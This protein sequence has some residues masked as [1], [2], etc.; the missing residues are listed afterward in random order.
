MSLQ[1]RLPVGWLALLCLFSLVSA[2]AIPL[3]GA[4]AAVPA[5]AVC[6]GVCAI[7]LITQ[8]G[9]ARGSILLWGIVLLQVTSSLLTK[10]A[11]IGLS[12]VWQ[13]SL[14]I[15]G[16]FGFVGLITAA[17]CDRIFLPFLIFTAGFLLWASLSTIGSRA[18]YLAAAY[19]FASDLK[20]LLLV[21]LGFAIG[22]SSGVSRVF[23]ALAKWSWL[24]IVAV[25]AVEWALPGIYFNVFA[26]SGSVRGT[27]DPI[28]IFP[29]R[30]MSVFEHP[31]IMASYAAF[32]ALYS[33]AMVGL[34]DKPKLGWSLLVAAYLSIMVA[35]VQRQELAACLFAMI[36]MYLLKRRE[37]VPARLIGAAIIGVAAAAIFWL[38]FSDN[39]LSEAGMW[40]IGNFHTVEHPRAQIFVGSLNVARQYWPFGS[41]LGTYG[42]AGAEK[43]DLSFYYDLGFGRYWW[44]GKQDYLLDTYWPNSLAESGVIGALLLGASY[45]ALVLACL[46]RAVAADDLSRRLWLL[47]GCGCLYVLFISPTSPAFQDPRIF[48][49]PAMMVGLAHAANR[50]RR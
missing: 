6:L 14:M 16:L 46:R 49:L 38:V 4:I 37:G 47:A 29:S 41:G 50:T 2:A 33:Y 15:L 25:I 5:A 48:V 26:A 17:R 34:T 20:P 27:F 45:L 3:V 22:W 8:A 31:S 7:L 35:S 40:G 23:G 42:G 10:T 11:G 19:Q 9:S 32:F 13:L 36:V 21:C 24:V 28:G 12:G 43:F 1:P 39:L 44:F 30:A 18:R